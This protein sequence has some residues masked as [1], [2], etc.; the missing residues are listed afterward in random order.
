MFYFYITLFTK[1][2]LKVTVEQRLGRRERPMCMKPSGMTA[3]K[4]EGMTQARVLRKQELSGI[5]ELK[6]GKS[7]SSRG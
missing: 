5:M 2:S 1:T 3:Y 6:E 7:G 4:A